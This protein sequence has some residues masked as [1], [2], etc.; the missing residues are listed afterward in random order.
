M[1]GVAARYEITRFRCCRATSIQFLHP[2]TMDLL[3]GV[4]VF[5]VYSV[6][7]E[8]HALRLDFWS[9]SGAL[10]RGWVFRQAFLFVVAGSGRVQTST[11]KLVLTIVASVAILF[12]FVIYWRGLQIQRQGLG[13]NTDKRLSFGQLLLTI[14]DCTALSVVFLFFGSILF[15]AFLKGLLT[16]LLSGLL[17]FFR[18]IIWHFTGMW[19]TP[20]KRTI[21]AVLAVAVIWCGIRWK[22]FTGR[23]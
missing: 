2:P 22:A 13:I 12:L 1:C 20:T 18:F 11:L 23:R 4:R 14:I 19:A 8:P 16:G 9:V 3:S 10:S 5:G 6:S 17:S 21:F 15:I 7:K